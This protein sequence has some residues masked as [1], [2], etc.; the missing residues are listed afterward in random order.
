MICQM[1]YLEKSTISCI[2]QEGGK[3]EKEIGS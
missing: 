1:A 3:D 2:S